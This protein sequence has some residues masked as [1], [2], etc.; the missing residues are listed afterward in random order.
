MLATIHGVTASISHI[1]GGGELY[2]AY[3]GTGR[4][5]GLNLER[6]AGYPGD[7]VNWG[8]YE[9]NPTLSQGKRGGDG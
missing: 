4:Q 7:I 8:V 6:Y 2:D 1:L 5:N 9:E 3:G